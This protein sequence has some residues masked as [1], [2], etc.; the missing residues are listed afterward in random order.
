[1]FWSDAWASIV[2]GHMRWTDDDQAA[3]CAER[4]V[5]A[6]GRPCD[7]R[8]R[9][10]EVSASVPARESMDQ[11]RVI[12]IEGGESEWQAR[13]PQLQGCDYMQGYHFGAPMSSAE[14]RRPAG[15]ST[16]S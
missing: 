3:S 8:G 1:M 5:R 15:A 12:G 10:A 13:M 2:R 16:P 6:I 14:F 4:L 9:M 11:L 7:L